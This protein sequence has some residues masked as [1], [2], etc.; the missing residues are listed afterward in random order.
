MESYTIDTEKIKCNAKR[1]I[2]E[3]KRAGNVHRWVTSFAACA[4]AAAVVVVSLSVFGGKRGVDITDGD[5]DSAIERVHAAE[6]RYIELSSTQDT[7]DVY[8]SF[9]KNLN[10]NEIL[11]AFSAIDEDNRLKI[12]L[13]YTEEGKCYKNSENLNGSL[14]FLGAKVTVPAGYFT[15][16]KELKCVA[17]VESADEGKYTD[18][19][20]I[21][22][23]GTESIIPPIT[24]DKPIQITLPEKPVTDAPVVTVPPVTAAPPAT[25]T[26]ITS[27]VPTEPVQTDP[28][29]SEETTVG[30]V[31]DETTENTDVT[32]GVGTDTE[33]TTEATAPA[34]T[35]V[36][37]E[38]IDIPATGIQSVRF[39]SDNC[40]IV[41]TADSIMF[42][43]LNNG[44]LTLDTTCYVNNAK[45]AWVSED[46]TSLFITA[47][48]GNSRNK[49]LYADGKN[50][51]VIP[52]DLS[53]ITYGADIASVM[54]SN[55]GSVMIIKTVS[56]DRTYFYRA[57]RIENNIT[58]TLVK[59]Y[60]NAASALSYSNGFMYTAVI[61]AVPNT[62]KIYA[63]NLSDNKETELGVIG[64]NF[65][66]VRSKDLTAAMLITAD[67]ANGKEQY[68]LLTP[69]G[70][71]IGVD[72]SGEAAF[73]PTDSNVFKLG[74]KYYTVSDDVIT[75]ISAE[76]AA[77]YFA[78][79]GAEAFV[80]GYS[81][82]INED[83]T[84]Y[85]SRIL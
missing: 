2:P 73:S 63:I 42:Y 35:E 6:A 69:K 49:V 79:T 77:A 54:C 68:K 1:I 85:L 10:L 3:R 66:C 45:L 48:Y 56:T 31:T 4:A 24:I 18:K 34:E 53:S 61:E 57:E 13:F 71:I 62:A 76:E 23:S 74:E 72:G 60:A 67:S 59:E 41:T 80:S 46:G 64:G 47:C 65:R 17:L 19:S 83:G 29:D 36:E 43:K 81:V 12:P 8:V 28:T 70:R 32:T 9:T 84:A 15:D 30:D 14:V 82:T 7:I 21:P 27:T 44:V 11:I 5:L 40:F 39:I 22:F 38:T 16:L 52:L 75:E 58:I 26:E 37:G 78:D 20:F 55:D 50:G 25:E 33:I 51:I